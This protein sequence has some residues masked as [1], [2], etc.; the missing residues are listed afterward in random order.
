MIEVIKDLIEKEISKAEVNVGGDG[1]KFTVTVVS[2]VFE[3]KSVIDRHKMI[4]SIVYKY[5]K[6]GEIHALTI[7]AKTKSENVDS[8]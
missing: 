1:S 2:D 7:F 3:N 5:I 6:T 8:Q 4:Y